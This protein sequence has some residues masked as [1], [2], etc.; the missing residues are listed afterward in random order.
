MT[1]KI[2]NNSIINCLINPMRFLV[3]I[4]GKTR[5]ICGWLVSWKVLKKE[6]QRICTDCKY[7]I[8]LLRWGAVA[9]G[10]KVKWRAEQIEARSIAMIISVLNQIH[11]KL[12]ACCERRID[13][14]DQR[15]KNKKRSLISQIVFSKTDQ[16]L[17]NSR[18]SFS[19]FYSTNITLS[20]S[21]RKIEENQ[22]HS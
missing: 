12:M 16:R 10:L 20:V 4:E 22:F 1:K 21:E 11:N 13:K 5:V 2:T 15:T 9:F 18:K 7:S 14:N 17:W 8:A 3:K 6:M 19:F